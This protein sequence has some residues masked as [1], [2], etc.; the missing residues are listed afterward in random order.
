[1]LKRAFIL[2]TE[3]V[4]GRWRNMH[5]EGLLNL[6]SATNIINVIKS[7]RVMHVANNGGDEKCIKNFRWNKTL[8]GQYYNM[9]LYLKYKFLLNNANRLKKTF[10][11]HKRGR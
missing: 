5:N 10:C 1:M 4:T 9:H 11:F 2:K 6:H 3:K 7:R 8:I